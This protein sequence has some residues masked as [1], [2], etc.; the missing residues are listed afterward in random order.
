MQSSSKMLAIAGMV[1]VAA[2]TCRA[3]EPQN[4]SATTGSPAQ[5]DTSLVPPARTEKVPLTFAV[6]PFIGYRFGG[7]F[8][9]AGT[10]THVDADNHASYALAFDL[11]T[12]GQASQYELFYSR[13]STSLGADSPVPAD[14]V[15]EYLHIGGTT[16]LGDSSSRLRP[17][18]IG[19]LGATRF[20]PSLGDHKTDFSAAIGLG[21]RGQLTQHLAA[22]LEARGFITVLSSSTAVFCSSSQTGSLCAIQ[23]RG[24]SFIQADI[25]AGLSYSF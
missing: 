1:C 14:L 3:D 5:E 13:E 15:I 17:Y 6:S 25:L 4:D 8:A 24:T 2:G 18:L 23:A 16:E 22:R 11:S 9:L 21:V 19:S 10:G 12:D 20:D 7:T